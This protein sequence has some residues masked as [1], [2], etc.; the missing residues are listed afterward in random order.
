MA[1]VPIPVAPLPELPTEPGAPVSPGAHTGALG[2]PSP[3]PPLPSS[4]PTAVA[5][6]TALPFVPFPAGSP[7][8]SPP[9]PPLPDVDE[10]VPSGHV[11]VIPI[12]PRCV[13]PAGHVSSPSPPGA[14]SGVG[15]SATVVPAAPSCASPAVSAP[16]VMSSDPPFTSSAIDDPPDI[17]IG[18]LGA[19][20]LTFSS[21]FA[22]PSSTTPG[23]PATVAIS[24]CTLA[25][26][27]QLVA[28]QSEN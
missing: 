7:I 21:L 13:P 18:A 10:V 24:A 8:A 25:D 12:A 28:P 20:T 2:C 19:V 1:S 23:T 4:T 14:P 15:P 9:S 26:H 6:G 11:F 17:V 5:G 16:F 3:P 22:P 27:V